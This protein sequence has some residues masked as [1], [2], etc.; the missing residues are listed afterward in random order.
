MKYALEPFIQPTLPPIDACAKRRL[1][2]IA[3][4]NPIKYNQI[5]SFELSFIVEILT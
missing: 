4:D 3:N 5:D 2:Q 1:Q